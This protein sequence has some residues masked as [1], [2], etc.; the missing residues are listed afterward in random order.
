VLALTLASPIRVLFT[1]GLVSEL[2]GSRSGAGTAVAGTSLTAIGQVDRLPDATRVG[3]PSLPMPLQ[4]LSL[5]HI[6]LSSL[7]G[8]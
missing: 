6:D 5:P 2:D 8:R 1:K 3:H 7:D 4:L